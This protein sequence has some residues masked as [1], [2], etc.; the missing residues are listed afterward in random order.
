MRDRALVIQDGLHALELKIEHLLHGQAISTKVEKSSIPEKGSVK[1]YKLNALTFDGN[2]LNWSTF[3]RQFSVT[4]D[5]KDN[6][7]NA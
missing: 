1:L 7:S 4:I 6:L 3:W 5:E 2:I